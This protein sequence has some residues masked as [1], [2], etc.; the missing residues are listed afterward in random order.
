MYKVLPPLHILYS[1]NHL[2]YQRDVQSKLSTCTP[3]KSNS[4]E[5]SFAVVPSLALACARTS[6][7][8]S[9]VYEDDNAVDL[10]STAFTFSSTVDDGGGCGGNVDD[11][12]SI[13]GL[14]VRI[15]AFDRS[16]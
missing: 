16:G 6:L 14:A 7:S 4:I 1:F 9:N 8:T 15:R 2:H 13:V 11:V 3:V 12:G 5:S 10:V